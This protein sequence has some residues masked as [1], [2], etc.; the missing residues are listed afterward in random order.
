MLSHEEKQYLTWLTSTAYDGWGSVID[1]GPWLGSSSAALAEGLARSGS[2]GPVHSYDLFRWES[3]MG[4]TAD[5]GLPVGADFIEIFDRNV[6][7]WGS[8]IEAHKADLL[9][10][11]WEGGPIEILFVDAAKS[12]TLLAAILET[13]GK[14]LVAGRSRVVLQDFRHFHH[15][16]LPLVF[17]GRTQD[18][19]R[20]ESVDVGTTV[21]YRPKPPP[22]ERSA[23][24]R[25]V[26]EAEYGFEETVEILER[27]LD[28]ESGFGRRCFKMMLP[29]VALMEGHFDVFDETRRRVPGATTSN[30]QGGLEAGW[31]AVEAGD[32]DS[33]ESVARAV[34]EP[35]PASPDATLLQ[36]RVML[37]RDASSGG[38]ELAERAF[39]AAFARLPEPHP[40]WALIEAEP[41]DLERARALI[42]ESIE[43]DGD[44]SEIYSLLSALERLAGN[45]RAARAAL[46][47]AL[48]L[49]PRRHEAL[50]LL[51]RFDTFYERRFFLRAKLENLR[52]R[53]TTAWLRR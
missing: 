6:E 13:F 32:L 7:P 29:Y 23:A 33:A 46:H 44:S 4:D 24:V 51:E 49:D 35:S 42:E 50:D 41:P 48:E 25:L 38:R 18:W 10:A 30:H 45:R 40:A 17:G 39:A 31:E 9:R 52:K 26:G 27:C 22:S 16:F 28:D 15:V 21:T 1:L 34:L 37:E 20:L 5:F 12:W 14:D 3:Y 2:P 53:A 19:E 43:L 36:A 11:R 8:R 47:R